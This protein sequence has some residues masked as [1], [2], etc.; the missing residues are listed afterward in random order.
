MTTIEY[1][2]AEG[3]ML[4]TAPTLNYTSDYRIVPGTEAREGSPKEGAGKQMGV[5]TT[6]PIVLSVHISLTYRDC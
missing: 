1:A 6:T 5:A 4:L 2:H 3:W